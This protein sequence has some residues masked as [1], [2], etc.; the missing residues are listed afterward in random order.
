MIFATDLDRTLIYSERFLEEGQ[1]MPYRDVEIYKEKPISYISERAFELLKGLYKVAK[2]IPITTRNYEQYHRI[3]LFK[4]ALVPEIYVINNGGTIYMH[5]KEDS[6]WHQHIIN[7]IDAMPVDYDEA[8]RVFLESYKGPVERYKKSDDLIWLVLGESNQIDFESV[9][10]F[11]RKFKKAGWRIDVNGRKIYLYP[12]FINKWSALE[13]IRTYYYQEKIMA[14]GD[15]LF[16]YEMVHQSDYGI[17]PKASWI[18]PDCMAHITIT[19]H[20]GLAAAEEILEAA[21]IKAKKEQI[22]L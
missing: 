2:V 19:Q 3:E 12:E 6:R 4:E 17:V 15:S 1:T 11:E 7:Q 16:D 14:A 10:Q 22:F 13:Y 21:L 5:G 9:R 20:Q 18:E 8:L